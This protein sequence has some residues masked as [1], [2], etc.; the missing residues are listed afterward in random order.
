MV[1]TSNASGVWGGARTSVTLGA[2]PFTFFNPE[3]CPIICFI[4]GGTLSAL[5]FSRDGIA[6]DSCGFLAGMVSLNPN[7]R[8]VITY[9]V[10]PTVVYYPQ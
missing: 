1:A 8:L 2:S 9:A 7:D 5:T 10:A 6:F 4:A 3:N